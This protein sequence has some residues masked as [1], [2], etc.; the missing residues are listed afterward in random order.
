MDTRLTKSKKERNIFTFLVLLVML[1]LS[2]M[3]I[4]RYHYVEV[5]VRNDNTNPFDSEAYM[6][7]LYNS[8]YY[9][10]YKEYQYEKDKLIKPSDLFLT[11]ETIK[12][13]VDNVKVDYYSSEMD[14]QGIKDSFN[15][16]FENLN[17]FI[18]ESNGNI[19]YYCENTKTKTVMTNYDFKNFKKE[20]LKRLFMNYIVFEYDEN[21]DGKVTYCY[22]LNKETMNNYFLDLQ[23]SK[24]IGTLYFING[25][26]SS[27]FSN[28]KIE[29]IRNM[30]FV[31]A[32]PR[33]INANFYTSNDSVSNFINKS[34]RRSYKIIE[35]IARA[36]IIVISLTALMM[37]T[38]R[39]RSFRGM[40]RLYRFPFEIILGVF[41]YLYYS[42]LSDNVP[43]KIV[44]E[45]IT[46]NLLNLII[47]NGIK[48]SIAK[49][50]VNLL[51]IGYWFLIFLMAFICVTF[52]KI[53]FKEGFSSY[54][55]N[56]SLIIR[57][58]RLIYHSLYKSIKNLLSIDF[59]KKYNRLFVMGIVIIFSGFIFVVLIFTNNNP[60]VDIL[61][62]FYV[63]ML[64]LFIKIVKDTIN[65]GIEDYVNLLN[66]TKDIANGNLDKDIMSEDV[67]IYEEI[68]RQLASIKKAYKKSVDDEIKSQKMK[69][70]LISNVSH[71]LKTPLTSILSY[72]DLLK[73]VE[74][75]EE[76]VKYIDTIYRKS[77]RLK[78]LI[79]DM[80]EISK[81]Q[82]G[83]IKL[84]FNDI[85]VVELMKQTIFEVSDKLKNKDISVKT[86]FPEHKVILK[87]DGEKTYRIFENLLVNIS[88]YAMASTRAYIDIFEDDNNVHIILKN[89]SETEIDYEVED[90][91]ERFRRGDKSRNTEGSGLGLS[92][93]KSYV[94]AQGGQ[95]RLYLDGDLFK[96]EISFKKDSETKKA[97][98]IKKKYEEKKEKEE[99]NTSR[100]IIP[101]SNK[102]NFEVEKDGE[103]KNTQ[104]VKS[105]TKSIQIKKD[106]CNFLM[107][108]KKNH[109]NDKVNN[110]KT[111]KKEKRE[112]KDDDLIG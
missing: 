101:E 69:S 72:T 103:N 58:I 43:I 68:K 112:I 99:K 89:I 52:L 47:A 20:D 34:E 105:D 55:K 2:L 53:A 35:T 51:N 74:T 1:A 41:F 9:L 37:P 77:E 104:L 56:K 15:A 23:A 95:L 49:Q 12:S 63:V 88:K 11:E 39:L 110:K 19:K 16:G 38:E 61:F 93:A 62:I 71:D 106:S 64:F 97:Y 6:S 94:E 18:T 40:E 90:I 13:M 17:T 60:M 4:Y 54:F 78:V 7:D 98:E 30:K 83:N 79:D 3:M 25:E 109:K 66:L 36:I 80:F 108:N 107:K 29:P 76:A 87:L 102:E 24:N 46:G 5:K 50:I 92:I 86:N 100:Y 31:Y 67:G 44:R 42:L 48:L 57:F 75:N 85:D 96:A 10:Y 8:N 82:T 33:N 21:G 65:E 27:D 14:S 73:T 22:G 91:L 70:E 45:T 84:E 59:K 111:S 32:V 26:P 28:Y 81:A